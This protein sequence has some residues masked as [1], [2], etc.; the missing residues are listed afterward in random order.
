[1]SFA[2]KAVA[3]GLGVAGYVDLWIAVAADVGASLLVTANG[4]RLLRVG[5]A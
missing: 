2:I 1:V 5:K 4:L 3:L